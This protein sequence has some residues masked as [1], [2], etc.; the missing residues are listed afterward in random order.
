MVY[1]Y[2]GLATNTIGTTET[3]IV[4]NLVDGNSGVEDIMDS[5]DVARLEMYRSVDALC[6]ARTV[7]TK[8]KFQ[9]KQGA[10][11]VKKLER[12]ESTSFAL[13]PDEATM[14][15]ALSA[16]ANYI[17]QDRPDIAFSTKELCREFAI[18]NKDSYVKLKRVCRY[19][20]GLPRLVC[21]YHWQEEPDGV[22]TFVDTD[23]AGCKTT[24][25]STSGGVVLY[26]THCIRHW[27]STQTTISLSS[28]EAE[29]HGISTGMAHSL[30]LRSLY[31]DL[32]TSVKLRVHTDATAAIG[33]AWRLGIG[34]LRH[35][36]C[37]DLWI[38]QK[39]RSKDIALLKVLG[40]ENPAYTFTK[41]VPRTILNAALKRLSMVQESGRPSSA[42]A[43]AK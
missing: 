38:Q 3:Q 11:A 25:R 13:T 37:E 21:N 7:S 31:K 35:L 9:K 29:L 10:K 4:G 12:F 34:K 8:N 17:A 28:G 36:D 24:R 2:D 1:M 15:R 22:D 32:G 39:V 33:I 6:A 5:I 16:R 30:A 42:P 27:S 41:Y 18:P 19:L 14:Y 23:F 40:S 26:G 20:V 43:T